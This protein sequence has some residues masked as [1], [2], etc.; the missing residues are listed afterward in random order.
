MH[1]KTDS[2]PVD[3]RFLL[4]DVLRLRCPLSVLD[5]RRL[6]VRQTLTS[7][8]FPSRCSTFK[9]PPETSEDTNTTVPPNLKA[10]KEIFKLIRSLLVYVGGGATCSAE[11]PLRGAI[12]S[13]TYFTCGRYLF[14]FCLFWSKAGAKIRASLVQAHNI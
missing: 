6:L 4:S 9:L 2:R 14:M 5:V 8:Q 3:S 1:R 7:L 12:F 13:G 10:I 11:P